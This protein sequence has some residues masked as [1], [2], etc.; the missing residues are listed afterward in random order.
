MAY[1][2]GSIVD[3]RTGLN[4]GADSLNGIEH[5]QFA[6]RTVALTATNSAPTSISL[7]DTSIEASAKPG[8]LVW[9]LSGV[10]PD[11]DALGYFIAAED[12]IH[13]SSKTFDR[14]AKGVLSQKAFHVGA[15]AHDRSD[16]IIFNDETG[17][18]SYD[19]D[20]SGKKYAAI[21]FA[22]LNAKTFLQ[23]DDFFIA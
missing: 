4:D 2:S 10:D 11:G 13:L 12:K 23:A 20:G 8:A 15:K 18:L 1:Y 5:A 16:R 6:D 17:A 7:D 14:R 9:H 21:K 3:H 22:Q 19:A